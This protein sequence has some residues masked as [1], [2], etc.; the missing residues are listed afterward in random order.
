MGSTE[1]T[2]HGDWKGGEGDDAIGN[3]PGDLTTETKG[4]DLFVGEP[5][6]TGE[7]IQDKGGGGT[8]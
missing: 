1:E 3:K 2:G 6:E 5:S 8:D 7:W 4:R